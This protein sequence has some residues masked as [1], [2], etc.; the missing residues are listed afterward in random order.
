LTEAFGLHFA[1]GVTTYRDKCATDK[2]LAR[3]FE[4]DLDGLFFAF[5]A[6]DLA[7]RMLV[8]ACGSQAVAL[9]GSW[10]NVLVRDRARTAALHLDLGLV[11]GFG[12]PSGFGFGL[13]LALESRGVCAA[14]VPFGVLCRAALCGLAGP[15]EQ[16]IQPRRPVVLLRLRRRGLIFRADFRGRPGIRLGCR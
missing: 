5:I 16:F 10:I 1:F 15:R 6:A 7:G 14:G 11:P 9:A 12:L 4:A 13:G 8:Q 2:I 3:A